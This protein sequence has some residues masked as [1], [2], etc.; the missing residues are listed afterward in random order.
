[1]YRS[2]VNTWTLERAIRLIAGGFTLLGLFLAMAVHPYWLALPALVG[3]N[4]VVF[5]VTGFCPM[6][7]LLHAV[8]VRPE[9][10]T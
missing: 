3:L 1:M 2:Q 6:A 9:C 5:S 8:G 7:V 4:L 10:G